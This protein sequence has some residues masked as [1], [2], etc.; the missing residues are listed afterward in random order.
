MKL[1]MNSPIIDCSSVFKYFKGG[2][3]ITKAVEDVNLQIYMN[4][5]VLIKGRSG[6]GK[7]TLLNLMCGLDKPTKGSISIENEAIEKLSNKALSRLLSTRIGIIFQNFNLLPTYTVYENIEIAFDPISV[8]REDTKENILMILKQLGLTNKVNCLPPELSIGQQ[9]KVAIAR[10]LAK[11][12]SIIFADEPTGS[13][14]D[15]T[16]S[17]IIQHL[18]F[19]KKE[20]N[21]TLVMASHGSTLDKYTD[22]IVLMQNGGINS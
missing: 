11:K 6:A 14:D 22:R 2:N 5:F 7:S 8:K 3:H 12:P 13:V 17:E 18:L 4:E 1:I 15:E 9:Q 16:A 19:L 20:N 21:L 10:T